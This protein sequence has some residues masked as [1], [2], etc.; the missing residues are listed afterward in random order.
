MNKRLV[1]ILMVGVSPVF[2]L[3]LGGPAFAQSTG[4]QAVE[5]IESVTVTG[6]HEITGI[7]KPITV[8]KERSTISQDFINTQPAGQSIFD[9]LNKVPGYNFTNNDPYGNS[10]GDVRIHGFDGNH[11][12]F[13]WDGMPLNDTG[14]YAIFTNQV[15]DSEVI[16]SASV[17]QGTTDVDSPT[18][19]ATGGV[20]SIVTSRPKD[21]WGAMMDT[22]FGSNNY[23]REFLRLDTGEFGPWNTTGFVSGSYTIYDKFK[24]PGF[25][26]KKQFNAVLYQDMG[27]LGWIQLAMHWNS[28]RNNFYNNPTFYPTVSTLAPTATAGVFNGVTPFPLISGGPGAPTLA[29]SPTGSFTGTGLTNNSLGFG[30]QFDEA[31]TCTRAPGVTG[32]AQNDAQC[33]SYYRVRINPSDTGNIRLSSLFHLNDEL[34]LTVDPSIQYVLA[35]GGGYTSVSET[36]PRLAGSLYPKVTGRDLNG[37]GDSLDTIGVYSPSNTNTIRY[38]LNTSLV[39]RVD[40]D[41]TVQLAYTGDFGFHRQT[42]Q[43]GLLDATGRP[44]D[45]FGGYRDPNARVLSVDGVPLR[46]RDRRSHAF[47][48]QVAL[49]YEGNFW[50]DMVHVSAG[51]RSPFMTRDLNQLCYQQVTGTSNVGFPTCTSNSPTSAPASNGTVTLPQ[52]PGSSAAVLGSLY[53]PPA[54]KTVNFNRILPNAGFTF[55]PFG[56]MHQFYADY[57]AGLAA[58]RTDNLYNGGNNGK[59]VTATGASNP[60]APGCVYSS[61]STVNPETSTNYD[62]GYRYVSDMVTASITAYNTQFKNRIVT[63]FDQE[64]GISI[65]RNIGS[66]NVDGV[67]AEAN[68]ALTQDLSVYTSASY[69]KSRVSDG[70]LAIILVGAGGAPINLAGKTLVETPDWTFSQRYEYKLAGFTFGF[71]GKYV[72]SRF[73]TDNNDYKVPSYFTADAD[74]SYDLGNIGWHDSYLKVNGYNLFNEKYLGSISSKPCFIPT[75][76]S[77]SSCGS[78]PTFVVGSPQTFQLTLRSVL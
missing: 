12:S 30:L 72:G 71:G 14:N 45:P 16:G 60:A 46:S 37:D 18:A 24:G 77:S 51:V 74:I 5:G 61:F 36:D 34:S 29:Y 78:L 22:S 26:Q 13:T 15:A 68:V 17:N 69:T 39:W 23:K 7:M 75:L 55:S 21:D 53:V 42:G 10:G 38:G 59:C 64:Q 56:P 35:N 8:P 41:N 44:F 54:Q 57:A 33:S 6:E 63:S 67:D 25:L 65:D 4:T 73:A 32:T 66:V 9:M 70:P 2:V 43:Y 58:P 3:M 1:K 20:V 11:I 31:P 76:P 48:N 19:A 50:E 62:I 49:A 52:A 47:L 27:D 40:P 28:N